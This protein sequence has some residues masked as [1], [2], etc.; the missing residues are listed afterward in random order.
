[1]PTSPDS[2]APLYQREVAEIVVSNRRGADNGKPRVTAATVDV[3]LSRSWMVS[4]CDPDAETARTAGCTTILVENP[5][6]IHPRHVNGNIDFRVRDATHVV[7]IVAS[8][9]S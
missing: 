5:R 2:Y 1:M 8:E 9:R 4:G 7:D 6:T 3:D